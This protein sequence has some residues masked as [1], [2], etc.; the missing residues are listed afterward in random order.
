[1]PIKGGIMI[2][3][4]FFLFIVLLNFQTNGMHD[5]QYNKLVD[6]AIATIGKKFN[7]DHKNLMLKMKF[8][9]F[10]TIT[11]NGGVEV[12]LDNK[13]LKQ[14][15]FLSTIP[16]LSIPLYKHYREFNSISFDDDVMLTAFEAFKYTKKEILER[17]VIEKWDEHDTPSTND[18]YTLMGTLQFVD[19][20]PTDF[21]FEGNT[22]RLLSRQKNDLIQQV[23]KAKKEHTLFQKVNEEIKKHAPRIF[24]KKPK[25]GFFDVVID[26][27]S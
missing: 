4:L 2:K 17:L 10:N 14:M 13:Q 24:K 3:K 19:L 25:K 27:I 5:P 15:L 9:L 23:K 1:M 21:T 8:L 18:F 6:D 11:N 12:S 16:L 22:K 26:T 20:D 7:T